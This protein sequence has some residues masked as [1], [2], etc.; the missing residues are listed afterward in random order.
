MQGP[1]SE[2]GGANPFPI[3]QAVN[4]AATG[5][6][7]RLS[8]PTPAPIKHVSSKGHQFPITPDKSQAM[9][10]KEGQELHAVL[11]KFVAH[12]AWVTLDDPLKVKIIQRV[13]SDINK[14]RVVDLDRMRGG[15]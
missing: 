3:S 6:L 5:E 9:F 1:F 10:E 11:S 15:Q 13:R 7:A 2:L 4:D 14:N 8:I 12:P